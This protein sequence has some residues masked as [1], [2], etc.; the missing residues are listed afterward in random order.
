MSKRI[1]V[2]GAGISGLVCAYELQKAGNE[3]HVFE[4]E[5][6]VGGRMATR[7]KDG[8][9]FDIGANFFVRNYQNVPKYLKEL[10]FEKSWEPMKAGKMFGVRDG[11]LHLLSLSPSDILLHTDQ[12]SLMS[13][14]WLLWM[15]WKEAKKGKKLNFYNLSESTEYDSESAY[16][17][18]VG[19][20][21][22]EVAD[23]LIDPFTSTY[24]FHRS[25]EISYASMLSL[26]GEMI[27]HEEEF[28]MYHSS[29]EEMSTLP[30]ALS[31]K[32]P[33]KTSHPIQKITALKDHVQVDEENYDAVVLA[34]TANVSEQIYQN[35]TERQLE[36][37]KNV[38]YAST[39][40][41]AY[42]VPVDLL[43]D[44]SL[45][46]VPY[47]EGGKIAEYS[48]EKMK[49][50][51]L[52]HEGK[53]L[54]LVGLHEEFANEII[55]QTDEEIYAIVKHELEKVCPLIKGNLHALENYD[56]QRWPQAM[57]KFAP[58]YLK[59]VKDFLE[60]GQ[61]D[62]KVYFC[63]DYLNSPWTEGSIGCGARVAEK[64]EN[65]IITLQA[66]KI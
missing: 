2:V 46:M 37:L 34:C 16:D 31:K 18:T 25:D 3:V 1:A 41:I 14:L 33:V 47:V 62:Q 44:M 7:M 42:R 5:S 8:L 28:E 54:M 43:G 21:G 59:K 19:A 48:Q 15:L 55:H 29:N 30:N 23:Y 11:Q 40:M 50:S 53:T 58:G 10:G 51:N 32:L 35:P 39:V 63:G 65:E 60:N 38:Q 27:N 36:F 66:D 49:G 9:S 20:A 45:T 4:K 22:K 6:S 56:L 13:R 52:I 17:H 61:G 64:V 12:V 24:Q 57:P 26:L